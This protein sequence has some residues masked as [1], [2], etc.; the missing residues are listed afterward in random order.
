VT[1]LLQPG[2]VVRAHPG[3]LSQFL[4]PQPADAT[5]GP[6][7]QSDVTGLELGPPGHQEVAEFGVAASHVLNLAKFGPP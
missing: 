4:A 1:A 7:G 6:V 3:E 2:V 5:P